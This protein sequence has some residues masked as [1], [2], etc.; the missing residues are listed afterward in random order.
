MLCMWA[1]PDKTMSA[2]SVICLLA[3]GAENV[4]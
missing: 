1:Q 2:P 3:E 4:I